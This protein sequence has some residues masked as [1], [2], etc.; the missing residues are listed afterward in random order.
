MASGGDLAANLVKLVTKS[1]RSNHADL[2]VDN[3]VEQT[4]AQEM[5]FAGRIKAVVHEWEHCPLH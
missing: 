1:L 4:P 3:K 2:Q 5:T